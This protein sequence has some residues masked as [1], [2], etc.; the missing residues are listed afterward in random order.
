[1][2]STTTNAPKPIHAL[3]GVTKMVDG[4]LVPILKGTLQGLMANPN[5][6]TKPP[7][8]LA[9][10]S[11]AISE[12]EQ[13][14]PPA[15]DGGK[16]AGEKKKKLRN[17]AIK[18]YKELAHYV[19]SNC[20][21]DMTTFL[22]SG[23]QARTSTRTSTPP[24]SESIRKVQLGANSGQLIIKLMRNKAA[25][26]YELRWAPVPP[27]GGSISWVNQQPITIVK[28]AKTIDGLT[29]GTTYAFQVRALLDAGYTDW[30][31]SVTMMCT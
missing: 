16:T 7:V 23:F 9:A 24:T 27:G 28:T 8:D 11:A 15:I 25:K 6:F 31:D 20:N 4:L 12:Y 14:I 21:D 19:E 18:M 22:L 26:S 2:T 13:S 3:L 10:Y 5:L 30:S 17:A 29:P 1:M